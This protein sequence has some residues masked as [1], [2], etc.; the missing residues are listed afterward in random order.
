MARS[1]A[2]HTR[3]LG[4]RGIGLCFAM[5]ALLGFAQTAAANA[6]FDVTLRGVKLRPGVT[7]DIHARV[8]VNEAS[9]C[10]GRDVLAV[11]GTAHTAATW[12]PFAEAI[13]VD[14]PTGRNAC[15]IVALDLPGHGASGLPT[16]GLWLGEVTLADY[17]TVLRRSLKR[18]APLGIRPKTLLGHSQ[19]GLV[20]QLAQQALHAAGTN[21]RREFNIKHVVLFAPVGPRQ[22]PDSGAPGET[23]A[24]FL[25]SDPVRGS[26]LQIPD[27]VWPAL[28]FSNLSGTIA[29]GAPTAAEVAARGYNAVAPLFAAAETAGAAPFT[30]PSV[31]AGIFRRASGTTLNIATYEQDQLIFPSENWLL[32]EYLTGD[33][34]GA[35][36]AEVAGLDAVHDLHVSDPVNL[37]GAVAGTVE[38]P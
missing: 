31:D 37:L 13:F 28:F 5:L 18:L 1:E 12:E 30:R 8:F 35:G 33:A 26:Y 24:A 20:I 29:S 14:N 22:I 7:V 16:G 27:A 21:L 3:T 15:R 6:D 19:G 23:L 4:R 32:Y 36:I 11:H 9:P 25:A 34:T 38:L 10:R 2:H 17:V